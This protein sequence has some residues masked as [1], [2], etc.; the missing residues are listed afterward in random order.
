MI[1]VY[2]GFP[3]AVNS[4]VEKLLTRCLMISGTQR[5]VAHTSVMN[6]KLSQSQKYIAFV[7]ASNAF[8][9]HH[10]PVRILKSTKAQRGH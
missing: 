6:Q 1:A 2:T 7:L 3:A 4:T 9:W 10:Y 8:S 5:S